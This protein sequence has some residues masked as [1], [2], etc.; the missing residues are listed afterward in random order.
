VQQAAAVTLLLLEF[1]SAD[2]ISRR[3]SA[4]LSGGSARLGQGEQALDNRSI[5]FGAK[6]GF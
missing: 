1:F 6:L 5:Q 3:T 2:S 4:N